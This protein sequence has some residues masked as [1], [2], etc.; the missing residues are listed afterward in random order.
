MCG[1]QAEGAQMET[2]SPE[3][4]EGVPGPAK[5]PL[6]PACSTLASQFLQLAPLWLSWFEFGLIIC[7]RMNPDPKSLALGNCDESGKGQS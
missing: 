6:D 7:N 4:I 1:P 3:D 2:L 5:S